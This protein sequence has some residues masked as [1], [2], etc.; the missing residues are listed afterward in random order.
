LSNRSCRADVTG[1]G[2]GNG[3]DAADLRDEN[4]LRTITQPIEATPL[5]IWG[6]HP[7]PTV[8]PIIQPPASTPGTNPGRQSN[9]AP[10]MWNRWS[11]HPAR[12]GP[13]SG[14]TGEQTDLPAVQFRPQA[15]RRSIEWSGLNVDAFLATGDGIPERCSLTMIGRRRHRTQVCCVTPTCCTAT[16]LAPP[17]PCS[18]SPPSPR[19]GRCSANPPVTYWRR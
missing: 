14:E 16:P 1:N 9:A 19:A 17:F 8:P 7:Q 11:F 4:P 13:H 10:A 5:C 15:A 18:A 6:D 12:Q 3:R 2:N